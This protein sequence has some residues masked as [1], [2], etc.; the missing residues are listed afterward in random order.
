MDEAGYVDQLSRNRPD[1]ARAMYAIDLASELLDSAREKYGKEDFRGAFEDCR[2]AMRL[3]S[4]AVL[5]RDGFVSDSLE[6]TASYLLQRY[7]GIFPVE[8]WY[9]M[10]ES[11]FEGGYG[12]YYL[13]LKA[14]GKVR[15]TGEQEAAEALSV[16]GVFLESAMEEIYV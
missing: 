4:S 12:L 2:N 10:E 3:A 8:E 11:A 14:A 13:L 9:R 1:I 5:F 6:A 15:K 7:P 16:A